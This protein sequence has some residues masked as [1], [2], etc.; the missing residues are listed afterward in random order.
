MKQNSKQFKRQT[1]FTLIELLVVLGIMVLM[2]SI[3]VIDFNRQKAVR[4]IVLAKNET[5]TNLRK[6]QSY[7]LSSRN[8]SGDIAAK[9]Y[10][11]ELYKGSTNY[12]VNAVDSEYNYHS[13]LET[14]SLPN[15]VNFDSLTG[16]PQVKGETIYYDCV[17][18]IFSA[19]FATMYARGTQKCGSD[20][21][22]ILRDP[23][24]LA[25]LSQQTV[26]LNF[27]GIPGTE[28][29]KYIQVSPITGQITAF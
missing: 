11:V 4:N 20:I 21:T 28:G 26:Y 14:I 15:G 18:I 22:D 10:I 5:V 1:G 13:T 3:V 7:M 6:V 25:S 2:T 12:T 24:Q 27:Q 16:G 19:P 8:I 17:Q 23:V 9:F 29:A